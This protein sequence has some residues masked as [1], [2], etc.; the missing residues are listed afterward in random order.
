MECS[1]R[2]FDRLL[3]LDLAGCAERERERGGG[4]GEGREGGRDKRRGELRDGRGVGE[5]WKGGERE[6]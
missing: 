1:C 5:G 3:L 4:E 6:G 2:M